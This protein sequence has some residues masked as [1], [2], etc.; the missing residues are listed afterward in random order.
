MHGNSTYTHLHVLIVY[1]RTML[2][3][4]RS[5]LEHTMRI[6]EHSHSQFISRLKWNM[7]LPV[8]YICVH[9]IV[10]SMTY[11]S[12]ICLCTSAIKQHTLVCTSIDLL[13]HYGELVFPVRY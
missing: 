8:V 1:A 5:P 10:N 11:R 3:P 2:I 9:A 13:G 7:A 12:D 6:Y 4:L